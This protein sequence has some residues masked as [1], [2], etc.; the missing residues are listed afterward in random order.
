MSDR[1]GVIYCEP[2][3]TMENSIVHKKNFFKKLID[4]NDLKG[5]WHDIVINAHWTPKDEG[6]IKIWV[7]GELKLDYKGKTITAI[8]RIDD[9]K[10]GT[11]F[12]FGAYS[13]RWSGTTI[14]YYD[15]IS[16][17]RTCKKLIRCG[18]N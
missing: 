11:L 18:I 17:A 6:F 14:V 7:N 12:R 15:S 1:Q 3:M 4:I 5:K 10:Y 2:M 13:Q 9:Y 8:K 16:R